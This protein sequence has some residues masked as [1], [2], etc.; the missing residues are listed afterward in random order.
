MKLL[1][2]LLST[3]LDSLSIQVLSMTN[4]PGLM[5]Y[6]K[7][8]NKRQVAL[9]IV[10]SVIK[11]NQFL[12]S[13]KLLDQLIEFIGPLLQDDKEPGSKEDPFELDEGQ[14]AIAKLIHL[15][16]NQNGDAWYSLLLKIKKIFVKGGAARMS[17]TL[18][19]LIFALFKLSQQLDQGHLTAGGAT[20]DDEGQV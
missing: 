6:M 19:A 12:S 20:E 5:Q 16:H 17:Y 8:S 10:K 18:P 2:K 9:K 11:D 13:N 4:Y 1:V 15:I 14:T 3:P 7:F